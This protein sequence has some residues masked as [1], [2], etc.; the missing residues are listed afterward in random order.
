MILAEFPEI[1]LLPAD[2][3]GTSGAVM[4]ALKNMGKAYT[5]VY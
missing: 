3:L 2:I 5:S 1:L 4:I